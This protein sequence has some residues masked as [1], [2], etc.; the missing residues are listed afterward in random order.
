MPSLAVM[1]YHE[2]QCEW[3]PSGGP[4][5][6]LILLLTVCC[7]LSYAVLSSLVHKFP[8]SRVVV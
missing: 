5:V 7:L 8:L 3:N 4:L 6:G 2:N 1:Q